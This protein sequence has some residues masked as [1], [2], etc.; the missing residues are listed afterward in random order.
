MSVF[1]CNVKEPMIADTQKP[2]L[3]NFQIERRSRSVCTSAPSDQN[4]VYLTYIHIVAQVSWTPIS[5]GYGKEKTICKRMYDVSV[6]I[7][8]YL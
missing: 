7:T 6:I 4:I 1:N 3:R 8:E 5:S 2:A